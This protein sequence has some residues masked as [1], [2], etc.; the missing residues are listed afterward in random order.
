MKSRGPRCYS[1]VLPIPKK[2]PQALDHPTPYTQ[3]ASLQWFEVIKNRRKLHD[4]AARNAKSATAAATPGA[5]IPAAP[6]VGLLVPLDDPDV[7]PVEPVPGTVLLPGTVEL[8]VDALA[9]ARKASKV[10]PV[11][12]ALIDMTMP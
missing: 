12:G 5:P 11:L 3:Q 1:F 2:C 10:L 6:L 9:A 7:V 8:L 4:Q